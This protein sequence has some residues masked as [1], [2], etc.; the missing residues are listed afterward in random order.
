V[1]KTTLRRLYALE[2]GRRLYSVANEGSRSKEL[3]LAK[4]KSSAEALKHPT[5]REPTQ[6]EV[7][8]S[9]RRLTEFFAERGW[10]NAARALLDSHSIAP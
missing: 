5:W 7:L 4:L 9:R 10:H 3:L 8:E 6:E 2:E 1:T